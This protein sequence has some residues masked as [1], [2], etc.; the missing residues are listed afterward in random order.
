MYDLLVDVSA[1]GPAACRSQG[2]YLSIVSVPKHRFRKRV[3][4]FPRVTSFYP[5]MKWD[6]TVV[7]RTPPV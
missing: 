1:A 5:G 7:R 3:F 2:L 4:L 6:E